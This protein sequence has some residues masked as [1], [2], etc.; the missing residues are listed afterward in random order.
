MKILA[1]DTTSHGCS[2]AITDDKHLVAE[3]NFQKQETHS[4]HLMGIVD[5]ILNVSGMD[6]QDIGGF[7]VAQGPGSFTGLRIGLST[8]KG[9]A[10]VTG[11]PIVGVSSLEALALGVPCLN[12][13]VCAL[14]DARKNEVYMACYTH[15]S[16]VLVTRRRPCAVGPDNLCDGITTQ[17][18][19]VGT[20][21]DV[22]GK[23]IQR[24]LGD[25]AILVPSAFRHIRA[26]HVAELSFSR[27]ESEQTDEASMIIPQYIRKSD[28]EIN[29]LKPGV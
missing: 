5:R 24:E 12:M 8:L 22:F 23:I 19:F 1:I 18:V 15:E 21:L 4:R 13:P 2:V 28:A 16:G 27:F 17:T 25:L 14:I 6:I 29:Q 9:L 10:F 7:A 26:R 20:G 11:K 3:L